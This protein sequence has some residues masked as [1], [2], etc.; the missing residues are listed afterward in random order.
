[1][2]STN[3]LTKKFVEFVANVTPPCHEITRL[4]SKSMDG[5]LPLRKRLLIR[6][7]FTVC[8]WCKRYSEQLKFLRKYS[9]R[10]AENGCEKA[11]VMLSS[12]ARER[13]KN[14]LRENKR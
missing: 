13:L 8:I 12:G 14:A 9:S 10:M 4:L 11:P 3:T 5:R 2:E 1:M 6:L 7:H